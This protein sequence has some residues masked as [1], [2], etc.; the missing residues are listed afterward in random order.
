MTTPNVPD[1]RWER[2]SIPATDPEWMDAPRAYDI[3]RSTTGMTHGVFEAPGGLPFDRRTLCHLPV[4]EQW[5]C[6]EERFDQPHPDGVTCAMC[7]VFLESDQRA[8]QY[9]RDH[10]PRRNPYHALETSA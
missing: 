7:R 6:V 10:P 2:T 3:V 5:A 8:R 4:T 1:D 9:A